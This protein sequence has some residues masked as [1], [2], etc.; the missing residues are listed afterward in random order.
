[1]AQPARLLLEYTGEEWEDKKFVTG[2]APTYNKSC[3][4]GIK[5]TLGLDFPNVSTHDNLTCLKINDKVK[6]NSTVEILT[7]RYF[8]HQ[9]LQLPYLIDGDLK[10]TQSNAIMR[11]IG[12]KHGLDGKTEAEKVRMDLIENESMDFR[13][14][15]VGLCYGPD[16]VSF[17]FLSEFL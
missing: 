2:P 13:N 5:E 3:W 15:L 1:M 4:F 6:E 17:S 14:G 10:I 12:R 7:P 11:H 9:L 8:L 16:F